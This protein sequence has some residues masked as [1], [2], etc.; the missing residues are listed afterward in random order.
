M[1][2]IRTLQIYRGTTAQNDAYTGSAG[3]LTMDTTNKTLRVHDGETLGG[4]VLAK[5]SEIQDIANADYVVERQDPTAENGYTW[6]RKYKSGWV[7]QG[8]VY[9]T[10]SGTSGVL[11]ISLPITMLDTNYTIGVS[12][13]SYGNNNPCIVNIRTPSTTNF[14][15]A[16]KDHSGGAYGN[17]G[18]WQV[19]GMAAS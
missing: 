19:S 4:T 15:I 17:N 14:I 16:T 2:K 9:N 7:E 18:F 5:Q 13:F 1:T 11:T 8:G 12:V 3:E 10:N 6:Y